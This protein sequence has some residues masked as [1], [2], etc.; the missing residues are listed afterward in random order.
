MRRIRFSAAVS[1]DGFIAGPNGE[2]DWIVPDPEMDFGALAAQFETLLVGRRT[3]EAMVRARRT[4]ILGMQT[5]VVPTT[6]TRIIH[7]R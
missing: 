6:L 1:L 5:V 7:E 4:T 3:F 2:A